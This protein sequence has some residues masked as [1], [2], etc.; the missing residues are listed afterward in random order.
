MFV[1]RRL[2]L[3]GIVFIT[4]IASGCAIQGDT[5]KA[6]QMINDGALLVDVR[7]ADE[8]KQGHLDGAKLIPVKEVENRLAEFGEDKSWPIVVYCKKGVRAG[9]AEEALLKHG[10]TN[11]LNGGGY[12]E[13]MSSKP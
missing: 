6:W 4:M 13:L 3:V 1:S 11:V 10:F 7:T 5:G 12:D 2:W 8:Y 9:R